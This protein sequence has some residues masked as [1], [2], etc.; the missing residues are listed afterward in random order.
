LIYNDTCHTLDRAVTLTLVII[1][2]QTGHWHGP[3]VAPHSAPK[4]MYFIDT[5]VALILTIWLFSKVTEYFENLHSGFFV[6]DSQLSNIWLIIPSIFIAWIVLAQAFIFQFPPSLNPF[7]FSTGLIYAAGTFV[8]FL[9]YV[10]PVYHT[11]NCAGRR[12][13]DHPGPV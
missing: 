9:G 7:R 3:V 6:S 11:R 5:A 2:I 4:I 13:A 1:H 12:G 8:S 10:L